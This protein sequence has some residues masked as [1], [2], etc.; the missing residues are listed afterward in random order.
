MLSMIQL[1]LLKVFHLAFRG[2]TRSLRSAP[3]EFSAAHIVLHRRSVPY[4][5]VFVVHIKP[6]CKG[7]K[8][9]GAFHA[10]ILRYVF[11]VAHFINDGRFCELSI[12]GVDV[13]GFRYGYHTVPLFSP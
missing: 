4:D 13:H 9:S 5:A 1:P 6:A 12:K 8:N 11:V 7:I 2:Q 3:K 10:A